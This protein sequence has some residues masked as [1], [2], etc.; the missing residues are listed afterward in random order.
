MIYMMIAEKGPLN[1]GEDIY[2][3]RKL[4]KFFERV[5]PHSGVEITANIDPKFNSDFRTHIA[6]IIK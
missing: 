3:R 5:M 6:A 4:S 2:V 1:I